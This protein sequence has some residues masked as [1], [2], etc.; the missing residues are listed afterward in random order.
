MDDDNVYQLFP[1]RPLA[2]EPSLAHAPAVAQ[3]REAP[4]KTVWWRSLR[5][6]F[7]FWRKKPASRPPTRPAEC[8]IWRTAYGGRRSIVTLG[9]HALSGGSVGPAANKLTP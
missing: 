2:S 1:G 8:T 4:P 9:T 7:Y 3:R 5:E 6:T